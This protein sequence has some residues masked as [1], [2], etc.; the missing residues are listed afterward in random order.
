MVGFVLFLVFVI[1]LVLIIF[2]A[3]HYRRKQEAIT[4]ATGFDR[5]LTFHAR[6][7]GIDPTAEGTLK[8]RGHGEIPITGTTVRVENVGEIRQRVTATRVLAWGVFAITAPKKYDDRQTFITFDN[9]T[10]GQVMFVEV[11]GHPRN[12]S[13]AAK[14]ATLLNNDGRIIT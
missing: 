13:T 5:L 11:K 2:A 4:A 12:R 1:S 10:T 7:I 3:P 9:E 8:I 14:I 6:L